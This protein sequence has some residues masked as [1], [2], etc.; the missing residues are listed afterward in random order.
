MEQEKGRREER[1]S[2]EEEEAGKGRRGER[3]EDKRNSA[4]CLPFLSRGRPFPSSSVLF[5][6]RKWTYII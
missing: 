4:G 3:S 2:K 1:G 6:L 5:C